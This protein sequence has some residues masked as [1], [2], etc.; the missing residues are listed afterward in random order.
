VT[1][2]PVRD[3]GDFI[4]WAGARDWGLVYAGL[5]PNHALGLDRLVP[6]CRLATFDRS[7]ALELLRESGTSTYSPPA[8][9]HDAAPSRSTVALLSEEGAARF[10]GEVGEPNLL[11]FKTSHSLE[12]LCARRGWRLLA[13]QAKTS[14][15]W[16]NKLRFQEL[17]AEVGVRT[18]R[19]VVA[20][21][22]TLDFATATS[23]VGLPFVLQSA[24]GY[25]GRR[26]YLVADSRAYAA[27]GAA[28]LPPNCR[29][30]E[31]VPGVPT[32]VNA[33]VTA[34][35]VAVGPEIV[36]LTGIPQLT[37]YELGSCG[38][39]WAGASAHGYAVGDIAS[40]VRRIG[41]AMAEHGFLGIFGVDLVRDRSGRPHVIEVN[42]RLVASIAMHTQ[43]EMSA[44][45]LPLLARHLLAFLAP[46]QDEAPLEP[47]GDPLEGLQLIAYHTGAPARVSAETRTGIYRVPKGDEGA[48]LLRP[49]VHVSDVRESTEALVLGPAPV[50]R[51]S[52][53]SEWLRVQFAR[54][55]SWEAAGLLPN[56][57]AMLAQ[58]AEQFVSTEE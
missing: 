17:A 35:G 21:L 20:D 45:R 18:P 37:P 33:C 16:E 14:R 38:N 36:Q 2:S 34:V 15:K 10:V 49:G 3:F 29:L 4:G 50:R 13:S 9:F 28:G 46:N 55:P 48:A 42:P 32:T 47:H 11:V 5:D 26:T 56:H 24:Y 52:S 7:P 51:L 8:A 31:Y 22:R 12:R 39:D 53:G 1:Q 19:S 30:T 58:F 25:G 27:V 40:A 44:G 41:L 43:L 54:A 6:G 23:A 57:S